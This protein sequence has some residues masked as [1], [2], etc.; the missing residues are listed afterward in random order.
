ML[1]K[2][3][4]NL[5]L[6][7]P[8]GNYL[9]VEHSMATMG[10]LLL[11]NSSKFKVVVTQ[12]FSDH[13]YRRFSPLQRQWNTNRQITDLIPSSHA[14]RVL[15]HLS[16]GFNKKI[17]ALWLERLTRSL[18]VVHSKEGRKGKNIMTKPS[19]TSKLIV[20]ESSIVI[21]CWKAHHI[22]F[23]CDEKSELLLRP[24]LLHFWFRQL[25]CSIN[26]YLLDWEPSDDCILLT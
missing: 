10:F 26:R 16:E 7:S 4:S 11:S 18:Q 3:T 2:F 13:P 9:I 20:I 22:R 14:V 17:V 8:K 12:I 5:E 21:S 23:A 25:P 1:H 15:I 19:W 24:V 6:F